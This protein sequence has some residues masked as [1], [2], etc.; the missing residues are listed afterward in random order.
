MSRVGQDELSPIARD[1]APIFARRTVV[2]VSRALKSGYAAVSTIVCATGSAAG[3]VPL[4]PTLSQIEERPMNANMMLLPPPNLVTNT[5]VA[6][7]E[8]GAVGA[9]SDARLAEYV[10]DLSSRDPRSVRFALACLGVYGSSRH[11]GAVAKILHHTDPQVVQD[12]ENTLWRIWLRGDSP[13]AARELSKAIADI[14]ADRFQDAADRLDALAMEHP[15]FAESHFHRGLAYQLLD[16]QNEA[17]V[18]FKRALQ[19]NPSHFAAA[20][21]LGALRVEQNDWCSA[22]TCY[23]RALRIHPRLTQIVETIECLRRR[24]SMGDS[25]GAVE[26]SQSA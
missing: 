6:Y 11:C 24:I 15:T 20:A 13:D 3:S 17:A 26:T 8:A 2:P 4:I 14:R 10:A 25:D 16:R 23:E 19:L 7:V 1:D 12:A 22:L 5:D 21:S 9:L 18:C